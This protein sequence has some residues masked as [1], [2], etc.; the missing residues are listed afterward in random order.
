MHDKLPNFLISVHSDVIMIFFH[1][2][3][4]GIASSPTANLSN[5][6]L[7]AEAQQNPVTLS[8]RLVLTLW[9]SALSFD[10]PQKL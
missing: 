5:H 9:E 10:C 7:P 6:W 3:E 8:K 2:D 1:W 4:N